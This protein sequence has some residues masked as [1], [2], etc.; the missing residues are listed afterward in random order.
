MDQDFMAIIGYTVSQLAHKWPS[1]PNNWNPTHIKKYEIQGR[2][3]LSYVKSLYVRYKADQGTSFSHCLK[4]VQVRCSLLGTNTLFGTFP[5]RLRWAFTPGNEV[6]GIFFKWKV[7]QIIFLI[8]VL[9][10]LQIIQTISMLSIHGFFIFC[11]VYL[12]GYH[13]AYSCSVPPN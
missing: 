2:C 1:L 9:F 11:P 10:W 4:Y 3:V 12:A 8:T 13:Y 5:K 7:V 6:Y